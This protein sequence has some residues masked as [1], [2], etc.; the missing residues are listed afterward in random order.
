MIEGKKEH[1]L[2]FSGQVD[3]ASVASLCKGISEHSD[4]HPEET[5][6]LFI[7]SGGG[8]FRAA[9]AFYEFVTRILKPDLQTVALGEIGSAAI[10]MYLAGGERGIT[11]N[12]RI[13]LHEL[14]K[15]YEDGATLSTG[16]TEVLNRNTSASQKLYARILAECST[17]RISQKAVEE[18]MRKN[19]TLSSKE[20]VKFGLAH[21][22]L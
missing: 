5:I 4:K 19:T 16:D 9:M 14:S 11:K 12:S 2:S 15:K 6:T 18:L 20:A 17:G 1:W 13:F 22:I 7:F 8:S 10:L 21:K 3:E